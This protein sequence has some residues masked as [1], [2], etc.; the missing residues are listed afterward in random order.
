LKPA[1]EQPSGAAPEDVACRLC[2]G[3]TRPAFRTEDVNRRLSD[4][5]FQYVRCE[6]CGTLTLANVPPELGAYYPSDYYRVPASREALLAAGEEAEREKLALIQPFV[7]TGRLL[8]VGPAVGA[9]VAVSQDAGYTV[10]AIE[11]DELCCRFLETELGVPTICSDDP[12]AVLATSWPFD[13]IVLWQVIEHV[14]DPAGLIAAAAAAI[15]PGGVLAVSAPNPEAL[16]FRVFGRRWTH[17]DAPRHLA[18][19]PLDALAELG[20]RHGLDVVLQ[21]TSDPSAV[22]WNRFGWR[23]S[24]AGLVKSQRAWTALRILGSVLAR[25]L[26]PIERRRRRGATY[27]LVLQRPSS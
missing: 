8:E 18:L 27:T 16:Q 12:A 26:A 25:V 1:P 10:E 15:S 3:P 22:G 11:M 2:G 20:A 5:Q 4:E 21:T 6:R 19:M 9:F 14:P 7:E 13:V 24:L 23:E 17:I